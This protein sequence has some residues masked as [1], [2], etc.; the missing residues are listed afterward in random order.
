MPRKN[1]G[2]PVYD[3]DWYVGKEMRIYREY[4]EN[5]VITDIKQMQLLDGQ[6]Y[7]YVLEDTTR[8]HHRVF[9]DGDILEIK[10][11]G[12]I[13]CGLFNSFDFILRVFSKAYHHQLV[14]FARNGVVLYEDHGLPT[15]V[16]AIKE[17]HQQPAGTYTLQGVKVDDNGPLP[18]GIYIR[19]GKKVSIRD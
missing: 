11:I 2:A 9:S 10:G 4:Y 16:S 3:F 8:N 7:D 5:Y 18:S 12:R 15:R 6:Y 14:K 1:P 19:N 17:K 13:K